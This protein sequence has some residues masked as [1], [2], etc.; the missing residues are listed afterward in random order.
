MTPSFADRSP[1]RDFLALAGLGSAG[2]ALTACG[3]P[4]L[5]PAP[6]DTG[7]GSAGEPTATGS[8]PREVPR[9]KPPEV[10]REQTLML[11]NGDGSDLGI[12][13]PY[14]S[15]FN[16]QRGLAALLEPLWYYSA[17]TGETTPWLA[18]GEP[19]Y[20]KDYGSVTI[21]TRTDAKW[22][23]GTAFSA[24]DVAF[25]IEMLRNEKNS[26]MTYSADIREWVKKAEATDD[27]TVKITF[28]KPA[29][30]FV[31]DYL[32]FKNDLGI[33]LVPEHIFKDQKDQYGF[34]FYDPSK[35]WP[36]VTGP[37]TMVDWTVQQRLLDR[38]DD[39]WAV[40]AG[41]AELPGPKRILVVP[42]TD[43]TNTAQQLINNELDSSLDL[44][45]P[46]IK[47]VV[48]QN[49]KIIAWTDRNAPYGYTDWWPQSLFFNCAAPPYD[50]VEIRRA[51]NHGINRQQLVDIGYEGA[52]TLSELPFPDFP[53]LKPYLDAARPML[54][55]YPTNAYDLAK[56][57]TIMTGKGY[58]K[59]GEGLWAKDG[60]RVD[61]TI[62]GIVDLVN[63]YGAILAEQL[64]AAGFESS[65]QTP[66]DAT[67]RITDGS[68]KLFLFGFAGAIA[69]PYPSLELMHSRHF[70]KIGEAGDVSSHWKNA[71]Y[72]K[73]VEQMSSLP[74]ADPGELPLFLEAME[75]YLKELPHTPLVQWMHRIPYNTT[76]WTGWPTASDPYLPG[77]FW[78]KTFSLELTRIKP[79]AG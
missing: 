6:A 22:S 3:T 32:Y 58:A 51:V 26:A 70:S 38:R 71:A 40:Q 53:P 1:R 79:A 12:C 67:T 25:S 69:D 74:V 18:E 65:L 20:A 39:W 31:F 63:D 54:A 37:Y 75:L 33:F 72:D 23:D 34:L 41:L 28:T 62:Y 4:E 27:K 15:G 55:Q 60:K 66:G 64:R 48:E 16:H 35:Q 68:A 5:P 46:V 76:Y 29:P 36:V 57:D 10:P 14:A 19:A 56:V 30:R 50:D 21:T 42:F 73:I 49:Q 45:P 9:G 8:A 47:Q 78:F 24:K 77:A 7:T 13:N 61:A 43:P 59:D 44:R 17:F 11:A 2:L 52:G